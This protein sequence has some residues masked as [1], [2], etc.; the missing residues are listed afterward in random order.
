[1]GVVFLKGGRGFRREGRAGRIGR[2]GREGGGEERDESRT[3][4][5]STA[6]NCSKSLYTYRHVATVKTTRI[7]LFLLQR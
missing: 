4:P 2:G 3:T 7:F 1:M 5:F 6:S